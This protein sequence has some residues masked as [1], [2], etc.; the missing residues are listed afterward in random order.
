MKLGSG[1]WPTFAGSLRN[2]PTIR[3]RS[4]GTKGRKAYKNEGMKEL[5]N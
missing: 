2:I 4:T 3:L 5:K 1:V